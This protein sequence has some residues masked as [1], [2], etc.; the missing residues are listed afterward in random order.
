MPPT[1]I[2]P[3]MVKTP[4]WE[5]EVRGIPAQYTG[6]RGSARPQSASAH[7]RHGLLLPSAPRDGCLSPDFDHGRQAPTL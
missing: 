5:P 4:S 2:G 1:P 6:Q 3:V 7:M